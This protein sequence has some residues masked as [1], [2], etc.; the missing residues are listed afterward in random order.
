LEKLAARIKCLS[1]L[2]GLPQIDIKV[3]SS[4]AFCLKTVIGVSHFT[5]GP[6]KERTETEVDNGTNSA[7]RD[8]HTRPGGDE[9][10]LH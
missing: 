1:S 10:V 9:A 4:N 5:D 7:H 8:W 6:E 2:E 3:P